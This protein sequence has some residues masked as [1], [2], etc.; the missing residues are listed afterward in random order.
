MFAVLF[1]FLNA[2]QSVVHS[3]ELS[4]QRQQMAT[5]VLSVCVATG[6][7]SAGCC[8]CSAALGGSDSESFSRDT[9]LSSLNTQRYIQLPISPLSAQ[10]VASPCVLFALSLTFDRAAE[11][12]DYFGLNKQ[13]ITFRPVIKVCTYWF[14]MQAMERE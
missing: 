10:F 8:C 1:F 5:Y 9:G 14:I 11:A 12:T 2:L 4:S 3:S 13:S 7:S 6:E